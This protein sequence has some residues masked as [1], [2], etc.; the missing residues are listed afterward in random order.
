M[1]KSVKS[2][3]NEEAT[4]AIALK[5]AQSRFTYQLYDFVSKGLIINKK[6]YDFSCTSVEFMQLSEDG[7]GPAGRLL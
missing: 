1:R 6:V 2:K 3:V 4:F 7:G 5:Y